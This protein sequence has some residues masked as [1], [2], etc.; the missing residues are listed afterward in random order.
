[1]RRAT[2]LLS[3]S[4]LACE[5]PREITSASPELAAV[6]EGQNQLALDLLAVAPEDGNLFLSPFSIS[7]AMGMTYAGSAGTTHD[8]MRA[9]LHVPGDDAVFHREL[10]ALGRDLAGDHHRPYTLRMGNRL[11]AQEGLSWEQPFVDT[12]AEDYG[13]PLGE[14]DF[15]EDAEGVTRD[16]NRWVSRLTDGMIDEA[17]QP[18]D[19]NSSTR[20]ALT[21]AIFFEADWAEPFEPEDTS[22]GG[23]TR[24]DGSEAQVEMMRGSLPAGL[25]SDESVSVLRLPYEGEELSLVVLLPADIDGLEALE[26]GLSPSQLDG[27]VSSMTD[28]DVSITLPRF[29]MRSRLSLV[30]AF[31]D[32]GM[33]SAFGDGADFSAMTGDATLVI[34]DILH[35]A[36]IEL[37]EQGTRAAAFTMVS[38]METSFVEVREFTADHPFLFAIRDDLT[39]AILFI[40]RMA[41]PALATLPG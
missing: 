28:G 2:A 36:V 31:S 1:M 7:N 8:E 13:A 17:V 30:Q 37:D 4:L 16:I 24:A 20:L 32:L 15:L 5:Q 3:L 39:G 23:F 6:I 29:S 22:P 26:A 10:G 41:D 40:G 14:V 11:W 35:E 18:G 25:Y 21:N 38:M 27:W 33:P 12:C 34:D 9:V 19:L